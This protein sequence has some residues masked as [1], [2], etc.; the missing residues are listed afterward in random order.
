MDI[1]RERTVT[2]RRNE[3]PDIPIQQIQDRFD[4]KQHRQDSIRGQ[5]GYVMGRNFR[6]TSDIRHA[7]QHILEDES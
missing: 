5:Q 3:V 7:I 2:F 1:H 6:R 4:S